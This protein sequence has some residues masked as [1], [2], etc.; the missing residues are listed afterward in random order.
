MLHRVAYF[1]RSAVAL[2]LAVACLLGSAGTAAAAPAGFQ[3]AAFGALATAPTGSKP[4]SKLWFNAGTWWASMLDPVSGGHHIFR[5]D[6]AAHRW[7]DT[8]VALDPR[9]NARAD[10]LWDADAGKLYVASNDFSE[11]AVASDAS[12]ARLWRF[13]YD[14]ASDTY[15]PDDGFPVAINAARTETLVIAK[16]SRGKLWATWAH[17]N[18][19]YVAHT[20]TSDAAWSAPYVLP[21]AGGNLK[22]DDISSLIA[23]GGSKVGVMWSNQNDQR[24][25]FAVHVDGAGDAA[26]D[27]TATT[28]PNPTPTAVADDHI[29]LKADSSGR[30]YAG[31]KHGT[32]VNGDPHASV[33]VRQ[34]DGSFTWHTLMTYP[35]P[36]S[37]PILALDEQHSR[38]HAYM[39]SSATGGSIL[40]KVSSLSTISFAAGKAATVIRDD[41]SPALNNV[42]STKQDFDSDSG[43]VVLA[44]NEWTA[45]YWHA[46]LTVGGTAGPGAAFGFTPAAPVTGQPVALTS[47]SNDRDRDITQQ[48]WDLNGDGVF[49]DATGTTATVTFTTA[50]AHIVRLR[51]IDSGGRT[52]TVART[53]QVANAAPV[54]SFNFTPE[55]PR[56]G[57]AVTFTSTATD[58]DGAADI[59]SAAWDLDADGAYDDASGAQIQHSF[60]T[61]GARSVGLLVTDSAGHASA[62]AQTITVR[63]AITSPLTFKAVADAYVKSNSPGT[64]YGTASTLRVRR[65]PT[66]S[67]TTYRSFLRFT[68][69]GINGE[70]T[71]VKL[72]LKVTDA[73]K[74]DGGDVFLLPASANGW[75]E[76]AITWKTAPALPAARIAAAGP[77]P[78]GTIEI[79]LGRAITADGTYT[80]ALASQSTDSAYYSSREGSAPPQ[81][82]VTQR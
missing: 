35:E 53:I 39:T 40:E 54:A 9:P 63:E 30:V 29:N 5:L 79:D 80:L 56:A 76:T 77:V 45:T 12:S 26:G 28:I 2:L 67:G 15:T 60:A 1:R 17:R 22:A 69:A 19:V 20:T 78:T 34:A 25:H 58:P 38:I 66:A 71:G 24:F 42:T 11:T 10:V 37:R 36:V 41:V 46:E 70:V 55:S 81:L 7:T 31:V 74:K 4:E 64:K 57:D 6:R 23:F 33:L 16:D 47:T 49:G 32:T 27:W 21:V 65:D 61:P 52:A 72:R 43:A 59:T 14:S 75:S 48:T 8:G 50:G 82:V 51:V 13:T 3:D 62:A 18:L 73:S 44:A 68:V